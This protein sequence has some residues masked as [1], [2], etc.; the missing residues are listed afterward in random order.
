MIAFGNKQP[1]VIKNRGILAIF[2]PQNLS[3]SGIIAIFALTTAE[4]CRLSH[5][6]ALKNV[7]AWR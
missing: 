5:F 1:F 4:K 2:L 7:N 3:I 6:Y